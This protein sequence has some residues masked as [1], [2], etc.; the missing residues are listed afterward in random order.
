MSKN[1]EDESIERMLDRYRQGLLTK[2]ELDDYL[3]LQRRRN[4][5]REK[6]IEAGRLPG[7]SLEEK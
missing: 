6:A 3:E 4:E 5:L 1:L 7:R 2:E